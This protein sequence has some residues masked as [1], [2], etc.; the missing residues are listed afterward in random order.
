[1]KKVINSTKV[2]RRDRSP[3][4]GQKKGR[5]TCPPLSI[6]LALIFFIYSAFILFQSVY[7][8]NGFI[9][10][11]SAHYLQLA[12]NILN[13]D[14]LSTA[15]YVEGM[16][17]YF[18]TW[19]IGY[20][21]LIAIISFLTGLSVV[22]AS[23]LVNIICV[24]L[25]FVLLKR[26]FADR[27][28]PVVFVF[29][30]STFTALFAYTW[31]EVPFLLGMLWLVFSIVRYI[32]TNRMRYV[33]HL[34]FAAVFL[35]FMRYIGLIGAGI[36]GLV[37]FYYLFKK[38]W[39]PM[40]TCWVTG[41][42]TFVVAGIYLAINYFQTGL[43]TGMER[44]PRKETGAEFITMLKEAVL[45][46][47]NFLSVEIGDPLTISIIV[48][49][50]ALVL[51][52]RPRHVKALFTI[53]R[54]DFLIPGMFLFVGLVYFIG[55]VYMRATAYFDSF[56]FR[57]LGP[58]TFMF[59]L[60]LVSWIASVEKSAWRHW[61]NF[62]VVVFMVA[63]LNNIGIASYETWKSAAPSYK[64]TVAD[65]QKDYEA[66][67]Y[68]SIVAFENIHARYLRTDLQFI[69]VYF[70]PYFAE[71]ESVG[72][73]TDRISPHDASGVYFQTKP[74]V[75]YDY[76]ESFIDMMEQAEEEDKKFIKLENVLD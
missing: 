22:W 73:F 14:G 34:F 56:D 66:I 7:D 27:T 58:A 36:I 4:P 26:L 6:G 37:G 62:L 55:I 46:E 25:C 23:K 75:Y 64:E 41:T 8:E 57:L 69:K 50:V 33:F 59:A 19:P 71:P 63:F 2:G 54:S 47:F 24:G 65:V 16:S 42:L 10:S 1:V 68:G 76:D 38:Q 5:G 28:L 12:Q 17:T 39:K 30:I 43:A 32:E 53:R 21:V 31:S 48:L 70:K 11:D 13:G 74:I 45:A 51:F 60:F 35:F 40:L 9:T 61:K 15:N 44:I 72:E 3:V 52:V 20:P 18:A 67:P 29:F 49:L